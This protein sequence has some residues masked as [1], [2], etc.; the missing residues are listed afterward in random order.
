MV[1]TTGHF[2][3]DAESKIRGIVPLPVP[4]HQQGDDSTDVSPSRPTS[5][6]N[7]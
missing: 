5:A 7:D 4:G 1:I 2:L 6:H 3:I